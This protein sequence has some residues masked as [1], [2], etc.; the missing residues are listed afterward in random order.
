MQTEKR[1]VPILSRIL[2]QLQRGEIQIPSTPAVVTELR[3]LVGKSDSK[4]E[5]IVAL[6][7]R[8]E[9]LLARVLQLGRSAP[10]PRAGKLPDLPFIINRVGFRQI[11]SIVETVWSNGCF[12]IP[13]PR[14]RPYAARISRHALARALAMRAMAEQQRLDSFSAYLSG[15]FADV[16]ASFLLWAIVDKSQGQAPEP[17][18]ALAFVREHHETVGGAVLK[19]WGHTDLV[20]GLVRRHH[21]LAP[22]APAS[23]PLWN[24][25][26][27]ASQIARDLTQEEDVTR[28]EP[29]PP[30]ELLQ[31]CEAGVH[32]SPEQRAQY[33]TKLEEE[34]ASALAALIQ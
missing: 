31:R 32:L 13:D 34:Y 28:A 3:V 11:S 21:G 33:V 26:V 5:A 23:A 2:T 12:Q 25:L 19:R 8:D 16:G 27:V 9:A 20:M 24:L 18:D 7:E 17:E 14:Y 10:F 29:W 15:L 22:P 30:P 1:A 6:L 4:I